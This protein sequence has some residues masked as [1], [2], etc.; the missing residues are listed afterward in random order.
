MRP[1]QADERENPEYFRSC[2]GYDAMVDVM[3]KKINHSFLQKIQPDP[4]NLRRSQ[5]VV[6]KF[7]MILGPVCWP[8]VNHTWTSA[9]QWFGQ[10]YLD[11]NRLVTL[12][13]PGEVFISP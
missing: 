12:Q 10:L 8:V 3:K 13:K 2:A 11:G 1:L 7:N 5:E 6:H 4:K 9:C